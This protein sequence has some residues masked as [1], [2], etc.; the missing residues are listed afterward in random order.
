MFVGALF[1]TNISQTYATFVVLLGI[2]IRSVHSNFIGE[3]NR[4]MGGG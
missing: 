1:N 2:E 3:K 4:S